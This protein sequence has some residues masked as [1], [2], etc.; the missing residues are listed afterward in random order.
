MQTRAKEPKSSKGSV[1]N[2]ILRIHFVSVYDDQSSIKKEGINEI[3][4]SSLFPVKL[5]SE[6]STVLRVDISLSSV[7]VTF[8]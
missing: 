2:L 1:H 7:T 6:E 5:N 8:S 4:F 3:F